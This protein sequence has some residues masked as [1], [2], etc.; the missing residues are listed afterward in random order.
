MEKVARFLPLALFCIFSV[1]LMSQDYLDYSEASILL[2]IAGL[3]AFS[4]NK[5]SEE[6]S[7]LELKIEQLRGAAEKDAQEVATIKKQLENTKKE[8]EDT[9]GLIGGI[10]LGQ[11][12]KSQINR[13]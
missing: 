2:V 7:E 9:K 13:G 1:K 10:K 6:F 3:S 12:L 11:Q 8:L 4:Q 5:K